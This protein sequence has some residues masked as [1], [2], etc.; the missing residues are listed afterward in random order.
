MWGSTAKRTIVTARGV[1]SLTDHQRTRYPAPSADI[2][3]FLFLHLPSETQ[4][5]TL[6]AE[7]IPSTRI[8]SVHTVYVFTPQFAPYSTKNKEGPGPTIGTNPCNRT[9]AA[10][11][12]LYRNNL[13]R[14]AI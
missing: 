6:V 9:S 8:S 12:A 10:A 7:H 11:V 3:L 1:H 5:L 14:F 13:L 2:L 4:I